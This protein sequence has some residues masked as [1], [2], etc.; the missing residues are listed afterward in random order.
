MKAKVTLFP[1]HNSATHFSEK[2]LVFTCY[3][4]Y[5]DWKFWCSFNNKNRTL[6]R[7]CVLERQYLVSN[8]NFYVLEN[9][10][11]KLIRKKNL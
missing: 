10:S 9:E 6:S 8:L 11:T 4:T 7:H 3:I 1:Y 2:S 5:L